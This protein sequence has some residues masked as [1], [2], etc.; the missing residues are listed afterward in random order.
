[1]YWERSA[2]ELYMMLPVL[3]EA[4]HQALCLAA[5]GLAMHAE[6]QFGEMSFVR[7]GAP[8]PLRGKTQHLV[9]KP[10]AW[11]HRSRGALC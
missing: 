6:E 5:W 1:M 8:R 9:I 7:S 11:L 4:S 10:Y 3:S 2:L